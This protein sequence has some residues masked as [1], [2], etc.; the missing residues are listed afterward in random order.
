MEHPVYRS[1]HAFFSLRR[2]NAPRHFFGHI[3]QFQLREAFFCHRI[4][5]Q[6]CAQDPFSLCNLISIP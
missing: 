5:A 4:R 6:P 3:P 1:I 2:G